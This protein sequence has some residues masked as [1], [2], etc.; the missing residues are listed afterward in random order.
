MEFRRKFELDWSNLER[1]CPQWFRDAKFGIYFHF[2]PYS[3][4]AY[5]N[6]W[7][8]TYMYRN[9]PS[10]HGLDL[11]KYHEETYG[12]LSKFG[13]KDFIPMF[14]AEKFNAAEWA[15]IMVRAG[16]KYGGP[17]TEHADGFAMWDSEINRF[18]AA[19]MGPKKDIVGLMEKEIRKR[20]MKF[21][22][23]FHHQ[24]KWGWYSSNDPM[25][26]SSEPENF[27]LYGEVTPISAFRQKEEIN[28][29]IP[30]PTERFS[31]QW[32]DEVN[33]VVDLYKP[34]LVYFD[35]RTEIISEEHRKRMMDHYYSSGDKNNQEVIVTYKFKDFPKSTAVEDLECGRMAEVRDFVW[36][37]DDKMEWESWS[38]VEN[39]RFKEPFRVIHSLVDVVS[40]NGNLLLN[41]GPKADGTIPEEAKKILYRVGDWLQ[42]NG[43]AIYGTR[44]F[45]ISGEGP[46]E[47]I[48]GHFSEDKQKDFTEKDIRF[49]TKGDV[50]YLF[51]LGVPTADINSVNL[52][53]A[54]Y[55]KIRNITTLGSDEKVNWEQKESVLTIKKPESV[56]FTETVVYKIIK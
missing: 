54:S 53:L 37:N 22:A 29:P 7:Y 25:A 2:G 19:D 51:V 11:K 16:A 43:E 49:T 26:D 15:D 10:H 20:G 32:C 40:K 50:L 27:D 33:E 41:V 39:S 52:S 42:V 8:S 12:P 36:Q 34:D 24:W 6:E 23:T 28:H 44:P 5:D 38:Y 9:T 4:P 1:E 46:T 21:I 13:Y 47:V 35:N 30:M 56:P 17:V 45:T 3:V 55:G 18:N 48:E 31:R 14:K